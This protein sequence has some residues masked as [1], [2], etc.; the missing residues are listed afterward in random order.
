MPKRKEEESTE[1]K[2]NYGVEPVVLLPAK[3][4]LYTSLSM[5]QP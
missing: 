4:S 1:N 2:I 3:R 5:L